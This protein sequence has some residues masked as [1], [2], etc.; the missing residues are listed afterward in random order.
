MST[1]DSEQGTEQI[2][3]LVILS[4]LLIDLGVVFYIAQSLYTFFS[5]MMGAL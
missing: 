3:K 2:A 4:I 5:N 1:F